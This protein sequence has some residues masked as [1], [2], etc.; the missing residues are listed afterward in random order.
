MNIE[1]PTSNF[2]W[3]KPLCFSFDVRLSIKE[4]PESQVTGILEYYT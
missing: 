2:E 3:K 4:I 1:R